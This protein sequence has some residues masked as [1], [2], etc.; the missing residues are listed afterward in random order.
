M[1]NRISLL[2]AII[3]MASCLTACG[4]PGAALATPA[5]KETTAAAVTT[6]PTT[7]ATT[8]V[9]TAVSTTAAPFELIVFAAASMT[10]TLTEIGSM[11]T[12]LHPNVTLTFN[13]DSSGTLKTQIQEGAAC[14]VFIS[15]GK[16][17]MDQIDKT[18]DAAVN[19]ESLDWVL[20]GTRVNL[21]ANKVVLVVPQSNSKNIRSFDD[22]AARLKDGSILMAMGN[23][24]VPVGQY[25]Q[26]ILAYF[27]LD[28]TAL[29]AAG[30]L[31]YGTNVKEVVTQVS[32]GAVDCGI[33]YFTDSMSAG[34]TSV[35]E[36]TKDM[37][38]QAIYPAALINTT[39]HK[40]EARAF[41]DYLQ[42]DEAMTVFKNAGFN[43]AA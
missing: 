28:E 11:Y 6:E 14:D 27:K 36:A 12:A 25:T 42:T 9:T 15:A 41:L 17:Q 2:I 43:T 23:S 34:L 16:K 7:A 5:A 24:D 3:V 4:S 35:A 37:C 39:A 1:K 40:D 31:S 30:V 18:A 21:L 8:T 10:E 22:M 33:V 13:F 19:T 29:A 38:G 32:A 26:K 20:Q